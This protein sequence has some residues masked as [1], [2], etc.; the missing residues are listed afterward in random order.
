MSLLVKAK[1]DG[2]EIVRVTPQSAGWDYVGVA[3]YLL[4]SEL[5]IVLETYAV[6]L[7]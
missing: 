5:E 3:A 4:A 2:A 1:R 6:A 7:L